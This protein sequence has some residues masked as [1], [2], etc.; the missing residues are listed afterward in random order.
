M[1]PI[2]NIQ[3]NI[4]LLKFPQIEDLPARQQLHCGKILL[5]HVLIFSMAVTQ[6][7]NCDN[8][9]KIMMYFFQTSLELNTQ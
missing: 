3:R 5:K 1:G 4:L 7:T 9:M 8:D 2:H 6:F